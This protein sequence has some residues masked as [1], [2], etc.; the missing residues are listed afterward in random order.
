MAIEG[1]TLGKI[2]L[3][4]L[5]DSVNPCAIAV[6]T[7]VLVSILVANPE[8]KRKVLGAGLAFAGAVFIGYLVYGT[9]IVQFFRIFAEFLRN[10]STYI[11]DGL[12]ILAILIGGL[13]IKDSIK[14]K[15]GSIGTEMPLFMRP[16]VKK[17]TSKM[18]SPGGAFIIGFV[19]TLFLLP[20][21]IGPYI[22]ASGLLSSLGFLGALPWLMYYN[23][24]FILPM[25]AITLIVY[26]GLTRIQDVSAWKEKNIRKLHLI[27]GILLVLVGVLLLM[28]WL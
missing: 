14:Y 3:L 11:Y 18:T 10:N 20:C 6:L 15:A 9:I 13:N 5:A 2:T 24:L 8:K 7:M 17:I 25:I 28:G 19:V 26:F 27:A 23:L 1:F 16:K 21:T 4:A 22:I 12:A